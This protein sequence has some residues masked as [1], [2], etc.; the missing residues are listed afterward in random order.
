MGEYESVKGESVA[1]HF[2]ELAGG[3]FEDGPE[4]GQELGVIVNLLPGDQF[5]EDRA[6]R[7]F[8]P[9]FRC[10]RKECL[11]SVEQGGHRDERRR[12]ALL[13]LGNVA[14]EPQPA[15]LHEVWVRQGGTP[16]GDGVVLGGDPPE[17]CGSAR[18][19]R[20]GWRNR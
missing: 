18:A 19:C 4:I 10:L 20:G 7:N 13:F 11:A 1:G 3:R 12:V 5:E 2:K 6:D 16:S 17:M 15:E 9:D 8:T 14:R